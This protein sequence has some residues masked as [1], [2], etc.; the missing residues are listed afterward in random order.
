[1]MM[2]VLVVVEAITAFF[3]LAFISVIIP[4]VT[5]HHTQ[6]YHLF[7]SITLT[8]T[9][10]LTSTTFTGTTFATIII[11]RGTMFLAL[12]TLRATTV[13]TTTTESLSSSPCLVAADGNP[14]IYE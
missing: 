4:I 11:L 1:M 13:I 2:V 10:F 3:T 12:L 6:R 5:N 9:T 7:T 14:F 8:G